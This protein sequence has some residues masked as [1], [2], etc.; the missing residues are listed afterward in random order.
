MRDSFYTIVA[1]VAK[2]CRSYCDCLG[3]RSRTIDGSKVRVPDD[4]DGK[5]RVRLLVSDTGA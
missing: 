3:G 2:R 1:G 4:T 5:R